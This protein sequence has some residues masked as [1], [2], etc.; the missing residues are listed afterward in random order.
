[1]D[2]ISDGGFNIIE[3]RLIQSLWE[4]KS[5]QY[6]ANMLDRGFSQ[7][8]KQIQLMHRKQPAVQL[9]QPPTFERKIKRKEEEATWAKKQLAK[10]EIRIPDSS[11]KIS[12]RIDRKTVLLVD[13]GT[14][15]EALKKKYQKS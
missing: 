1:M 10:K 6:I 13:A 3:I 7:V 15:I 5:V 14:D 12:V 4:T 8:E 11:Q 9:Y 2:L